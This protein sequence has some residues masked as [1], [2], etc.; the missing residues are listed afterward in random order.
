MPDETVSPES[1]LPDDPALLQGIVRELLA[2]NRELQR[3]HDQLAHRLDDGDRPPLHGAGLEVHTVE[4]VRRR[5][6]CPESRAARIQADD[7]E[8]AGQALAVSLDDLAV[9]AEAEHLAVVGEQ[10]PAGAVEGRQEL[11]PGGDPQRRVVVHTPCTLRHALGQPRLLED[12]LR[13]GGFTLAA[14]PANPL[15]CGSAGSYSLLQPQ[16]SARLAE[17]AVAALAADAPALIVTANVGCQLQLAAASDLPVCHWI[18][19]FDTSPRDR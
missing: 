3:R 13:R 10:D 18:E 19:L 1:H 15:C 12:L 14:A 2:A 6:R 11:Q 4:G 16:I 7:E 17:R 9:R 5:A 8:P